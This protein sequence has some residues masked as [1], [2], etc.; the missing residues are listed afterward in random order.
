MH[1]CGEAARKHAREAWLKSHESSYKP[2]VSAVNRPVLERKLQSK[3]RTGAA[4]YV[5]L[6]CGKLT[7]T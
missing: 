6:A 1:G 7:R 5:V 4:A 2:S 3:V